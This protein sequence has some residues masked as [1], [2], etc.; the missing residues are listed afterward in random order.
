MTPLS[1]AAAAV[2]VLAAG[3]YGAA[4]ALHHTS[5]PTRTGTGSNAELTATGCSGL[6]LAG[7]TLTRT[8][9]TDLVIT[10]TDGGQVTV[11]TTNTTA[12]YR[13]TTG[14]LGDITDGERVLV[15]GSLDGGTLTATSVGELPATVTQPASPGSELRIGLASGTVANDH[16][17]G[18]TVVEADG[19]RI[20]VVTSASVTV[21]AAKRI[22]VAQLKTGEVTSAVGTAGTDG[23]LTAT[24]VEQDAVPASTWQKLR[25]QAPSGLPGALPSISAPKISLN[26]LGCSPAAITSSYILADHLQQ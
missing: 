3:G 7:G 16:D 5:S 14:T 18:F 24:T 6:E 15:T 17:G 11:P 19:S 8:A 20:T 13:E 10:T 21:I 25:P 1:A 22:T 2:L 26:G 4:R 12:I 9:A 23:M